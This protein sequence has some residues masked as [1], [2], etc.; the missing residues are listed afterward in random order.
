MKRN[1]RIFLVED[2]LS[3]G[4]V[5]KAYLEIHG[6]ELEWVNDG[7][8]ALP[9]LQ[10]SSF[11]L[12]ILDVMLPHVDG[13]QLAEQI[14]KMHPELPFI[15]MTAKTLKED[16]IKGYRLGADDYIKKPFDSEI[17]LL[18]LQ[19][20]LNRNT[21]FS[22]G[23]QKSDLNIGLFQLNPEYRELTNTATNRSQKLSPKEAE[24]M[25]LLLDS[26]EKVLPR[27]EALRKIWGD[28]NYFTKRSMDVYI[29]KLRKFLKEDPRIEILNIHGSGFRLICKET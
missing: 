5:L 21:D 23:L 13:F 7:K 4:S 20:I 22:N 6:Y 24:L 10:K 3:F 16:E 26:K 28:D 12:C 14:K 8:N 29:T 18:K 17:L 15:F 25:I 19:A 11:D 2:D 9:M 27:D 1:A